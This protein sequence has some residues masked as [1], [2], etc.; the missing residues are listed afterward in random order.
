M[1]VRIVLY[2]KNTAKGVEAN[3][4]NKL[5]FDNYEWLFKVLYWFR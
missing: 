5:L 1:D 3:V 2:N 4:A